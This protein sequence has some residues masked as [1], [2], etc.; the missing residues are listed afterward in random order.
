MDLAKIWRWWLD[1]E[2]RPE[3][4]GR[5]GMAIT[6]NTK[7]CYQCDGGLIDFGKN[8]VGAGRDCENRHPFIRLSVLRHFSKSHVLTEG[9]PLTY[10]HMRKITSISSIARW[11][12]IARGRE[13]K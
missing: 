5:A 7:A 1:L 4:N 9:V 12:N 13:I 3:L 10:I 11:L 2:A 6:L 8:M